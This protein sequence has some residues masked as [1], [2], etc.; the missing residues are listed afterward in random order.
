MLRSV[1]DLF[2]D[3]VASGADIGAALCVYIDGEKK[4]DLW[5]GT[6]DPTTGRAWTHDTLVPVFS[7]SKGVLT[8]CLLMLVEDGRVSISDRVSDHWPEFAASGKEDVTIEQVLAHRAGLPLV[9]TTPSLDEL[10]TGDAIVATLETQAPLWEPGTDHA[11]H[12]VTFGSL[13]GEVIRR[14]TAQSAGQFLHATAASAYGL[15]TWIGLPPSEL[16]RVATVIAPPDAWTE[17]ATLDMIRS[18]VERD[19]RVLRAVTMNGALQI[20]V[21]GIEMECSLNDPDVLVRELP[22]ANCTTTARSLAKFYAAAIGDM[23]GR[24]PFLSR[25]LR[26][27]A[28][29]VRSRGDG[30]FGLPGVDNRW[31]LGFQVTGPVRPMLGTSS[32]GHDGAGGALAFADHAHGVAFAYTPNQMGGIPDERANALVSEVGACLRTSGR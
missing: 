18:H 2:A 26:E 11:Y 13:I 17:S 8:L 6:A 21:P 28:T 22:A 29:R 12:A 24:G 3:S 27:D 31:G 16:D 5:G 10:L 30:F 4:L 23:D 1:A 19:D 9:E 32:F 7:C 15:D 25:E 20:P 14:V